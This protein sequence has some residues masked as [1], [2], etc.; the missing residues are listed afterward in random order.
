[1][2]SRNK[3]N[4]QSSVSGSH[5]LKGAV[6]VLTSMASS[7]PQQFCCFFTS[8]GCFGESSYVLFAQMYTIIIHSFQ[9]LDISLALLLRRKM[10]D[11]SSLYPLETLRSLSASLSP[12]LLLFLLLSHCLSEEV[13]SWWK[14]SPFLYHQG[15]LYV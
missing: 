4:C 14:S 2:V 12:S 8:R 6:I 1:M 5:R 10:F 13:S 15:T 3:G 9:N 11:A 7:S